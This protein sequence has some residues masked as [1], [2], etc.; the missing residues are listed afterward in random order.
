MQ[1]SDYKNLLT[2]QAQLLLL[3]STDDFWG[4]NVKPNK[5]TENVRE[6]ATEV[7]CYTFE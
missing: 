5:L 1:V 4:L 7:Q 2:A 3:L 6:R